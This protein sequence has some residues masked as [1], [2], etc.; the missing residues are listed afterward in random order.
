MINCAAYTQGRFYNFRMESHWGLQ[1]QRGSHT[2]R[3]RF[4]PNRPFL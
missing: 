3:A 4:T 1:F 2:C